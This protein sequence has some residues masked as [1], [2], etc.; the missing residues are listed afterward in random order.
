MMILAAILAVL[1]VILFIPVKLAVTYSN[2]GLSRKR[3]LSLKYA[4]IKCRI[5]PKSKKTKNPKKAQKAEE[6]EQEK[7][8]DGK[9]FSFE[10][11]KAEIERY[12][13][14]FNA[15][16]ADVI[17]LLSYTARRAVI[18]DK[19]EVAS[20]FGFED[21]MQTGIFTGIYN[22][23]IYSVMG[24]IHHNSHLRDMDIKLQPVYGKNCF[25]Y[26]F[27]CIMRIKT[28]HIIVVAVKGLI[29]FMKVKRLCRR[30]EKKD[31]E[32]GI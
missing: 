30:A 8:E 32:R 11:K 21:A 2:D 29:L 25:N 1:A 19:V 9:P 20:E 5:Y 6:K 12:I 10:K 7:K 31:K 22:G 28:A 18:F 17:K 3:E 4:F 15:V 16:K 14:L 24:V 26:R 27:F 23:F 13:E